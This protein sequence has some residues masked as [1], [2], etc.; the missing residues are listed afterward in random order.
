MS[1][2]YNSKG[3]FATFEKVFSN[4]VRKAFWGAKNMKDRCFNEEKFFCPLI[5]AYTTPV[6]CMEN[7]ETK[8]ETIPDEYK[9][10]KNWKEICKVCK[11]Q[12]C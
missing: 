3:Q 8:E 9:Q 6:D 12:K 2:I 5:D 11:Y 4:S 7:R 1:A 10:K